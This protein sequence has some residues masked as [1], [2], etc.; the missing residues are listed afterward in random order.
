[1]AVRHYV[2][3]VAP[4]GG[5][6]YE[7]TD[8]SG[9]GKH[10]TDVTEYVTEGTAWGAGDVQDNCLLECNYSK[11]GTIH[12]LTTENTLSVN[13]RFTATA[14]WN[15]GDALTLTGTTMTCK[16][17]NG[18][19][20]PGGAWESGAV[21]TCYKAGNTLY[22]DLPNT[23]SYTHTSVAIGGNNQRMMYCGKQGKLVML[24]F[25]IV[26]MPLN[27]G[28]TVLGTGIVPA[29]Y[30]PGGRMV[31]PLLRPINTSDTAITGTTSVVFEVNSVG[32]VAV[33][34]TAELGTGWTINGVMPYFVS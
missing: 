24:S 22:F 10:I 31:S 16:L 23:Q 21:V 8:A 28:K 27:A 29:E 20:L 17:K 13:L 3:E 15:E 33:Y 26:N 1:M 30:R 12:A 14:V 32:T 9:G 7:I 34:A 5:R 6:V 25:D 19:S 11:T 4:S 2:D 18:D